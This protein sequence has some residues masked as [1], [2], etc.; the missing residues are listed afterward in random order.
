MAEICHRAQALASE[1]NSASQAAVSS[2]DQIRLENRSSI[3]IRDSPGKAKHRNINISLG[4]LKSH[5]ALI[6]STS[7][8]KNKVKYWILALPFRG[9]S[10]F[11]LFFFLRFNVKYFTLSLPFTLYTAA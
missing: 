3:P 2:A 4:C 8:Y 6:S 1:G 9:K 5:K 11:S 7:S 10:L